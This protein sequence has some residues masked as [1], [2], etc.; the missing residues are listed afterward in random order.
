MRRGDGVTFIFE[1]VEGLR[2]RCLPDGVVRWKI[3]EQAGE[4]AVIYLKFVD[5][6][7]ERV[8]VRDGPGSM[9]PSDEVV[10]QDTERLEFPEL[11][12]WD[13]KERK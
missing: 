13:E 6:V 10:V 7:E 9:R 12:V 5:R 1:S 3:R 8:L 4:Y 11:C 2:L